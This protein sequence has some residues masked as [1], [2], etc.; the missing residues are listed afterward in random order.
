[1]ENSSGPTDALILELQVKADGVHRIGTPVDAQITSEDSLFGRSAGEFGTSISLFA[2]DG[3]GA[4]KSVPVQLDPG[5]RLTWLLEAPLDPN[6]TRRYRC[7]IAKVHGGA[8]SSETA[9]VTIRLAGDHV[10]FTRGS[11]LLTRYVYLGNWK[12]YF[13]PVMV[14]AGNVVRGASSEHQHQTGL[15]FAYG[16]HGGGGTTN[17]WSDWDEPPYGPCGKIV[18]RGFDRLEG[19]PVY[20]RLLER[21]TYTRPDGPRLFSELR[22]VRIMP[23]ADG[24]LLFDI[25]RRAERPAEAGP[26]PFIFSARV[27]DT[28]RLVDLRRRDDNGIPQ[29]I[30]GPGQLT[31]PQ[32][33][34]LQTPA[35][36]TY[37]TR[38]AWLDWS[39]PV[40]KGVAGLAFFDH[41][42]N[43]G[44]ERGMTGAGYGCMTLTREHP[45]GETAEFRYGALAH[46]DDADKARVAGRYRDYTQPPSVRIEVV[47][48]PPKPEQSH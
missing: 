22:D 16:G 43:P 45:G 35:T 46:V 34:E 3:P 6:E 36:A 29:P 33:P 17:V 32:A 28:M 15:F 26:W 5:G 47:H 2:L 24:N 21:V 44:D 38:S 8:T 12:P 23:L 25:V 7:V 37:R 42:A 20:G 4:G 13:W 14:Q 11:R 18:H 10:W 1:M 19:G 39:G 48:R 41:P 40:G 31:A 9:N 27:A 30:E